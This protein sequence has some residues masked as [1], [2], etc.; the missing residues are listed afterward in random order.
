MYC[1]GI[2]A[3]SKL[4]CLS[5]ACRWGDSE[6]LSKWSPVPAGKRENGELGGGDRLSHLRWDCGHES[7]K[8]PRSSSCWTYVTLRVR[9]VRAV[10]ATYRDARR[11][12]RHAASH[13]IARTACA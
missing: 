3:D 1:V 6:H 9:D 8:T 4:H 11:T 12:F 7:L 13:R 2:G 10:L 5:S